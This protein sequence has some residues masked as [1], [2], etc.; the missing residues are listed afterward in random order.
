MAN[1]I[2]PLIKPGLLVIA[3]VEGSHL[4]KDWPLHIATGNSKQV[5]QNTE[6]SHCEICNV[7]N[8]TAEDGVIALC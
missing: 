6:S 2:P 5:L 3:S 8:T 1:S 4:S 7:Q